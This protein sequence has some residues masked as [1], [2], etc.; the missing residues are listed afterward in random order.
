[1]ANTSIF[2]LHEKINKSGMQ[3]QKTA[4]KV[5]SGPSPIGNRH[6]P[7]FKRGWEVHLSCSAIKKYG[8]EGAFLL[9]EL[10]RCY[11]VGQILCRSNVFVVAY[12]QKDVFYWKAIHMN[13][14]LLV[15]KPSCSAAHNNFSFNIRFIR[16]YRESTTS[17]F[18]NNLCRSSSFWQMEPSRKD[19]L[20]WI[21][22]CLV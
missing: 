3:D 22:Y 10:V 20:T 13:R 7:I 9:V 15:L 19:V 4:H 11:V 12:L 8:E 2:L 14:F 5:P 18:T 1:M 6:P 16:P 21:I 17:I